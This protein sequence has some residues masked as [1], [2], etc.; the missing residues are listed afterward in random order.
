MLF[1]KKNM[2]KLAKGNLAVLRIAITEENASLFGCQ[3]TLR[4]KMLLCSAMFAR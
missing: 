3:R 4:G 1:A 2:P